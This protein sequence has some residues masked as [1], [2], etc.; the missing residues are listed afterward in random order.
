[1]QAAMSFASPIVIA[2]ILACATL[3][4]IGR[5]AW[6]WH[7]TDF[8]QRPQTWRL[9]V[10]LLAQPIVAGLLLLTLFPPTRPVASGV[11]VIATAGASPTMIDAVPKGEHLVVLPE[12]PASTHKLA[13]AERMPDLGSAL[14]RYPYSQQLRVIGGGLVARDRDAAGGRAL[15]FHPG[16]LPRGIVGL[17]LPADV[18]AG[19]GFNVSGQLEGLDGIAVSL[20]DP[21]GSVIDRAQ[22]GSDGR[23]RLHGRAKGPGPATWRVH[24]GN[25]GTRM[26]SVDAPIRVMPGTALRVQLVVGAPNAELK[27]LRRWADDAGLRMDARISLGAGME[28]GNAAQGFSKS[29]LDELDLL[30]LDQRTW[31]AQ[32]SQTHAMVNHAVSD[33]LGLLLLLTEPVSAAGKAT[34]GQSGFTVSPA[35]AGRSVEIEARGGDTAPDPATAAAPTVLQAALSLPA[36][37]VSAIDG[38]TLLAD[39]AARDAGTWRAHG[40]GRYGVATFSDSY[41]MVLAGDTSR[42]GELWSALFSTLGRAPPTSTHTSPVAPDSADAWVGERMPLCDLQRDARIDAPDG[43]STALLLDPA[44]GKR[45]C[46]GFWP[47]TPGWHW[48]RN[49]NNRTAFHVR[50]ADD[51]LGLHAM[52]TR[53]ATLQLAST[54]HAKVAEHDGL[55]TTAVVAMAPPTSPDPRWPWFCAWLVM[56]AGLWWLERSNLGA[57]HN[58]PP[59]SGR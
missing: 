25:E 10:L 3:V 22:A 4:A 45:H 18:T 20:L 31:Q 56:A 36:L 54:A 34:L 12:A 8:D 37:N 41:R 40:L 24:V 28:I 35:P 11:L 38:T 7:R 58:R 59:I 47:T 52:A 23:F 39:P 55:A 5:I 50:A 14:R 21:A 26:G 15:E 30:V 43:T 44:T 6:H 19:A 42:Y 13:R 48:L 57:R 53:E 1:M 51:G 16:P 33:G 32:G 49:A 29:S 27:Y 17:W 46:A 2:T 9:V